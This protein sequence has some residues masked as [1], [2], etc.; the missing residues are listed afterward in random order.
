MAKKK[1]TQPLSMKSVQ[2]VHDPKAA[3]LWIDMYS[4]LLLKHLKS[5]IHDH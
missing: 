4:E 3:M 2:F 1:P 5:K